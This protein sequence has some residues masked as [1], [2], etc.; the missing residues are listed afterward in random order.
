V[1]NERGKIYWTQKG[2]SNA[3]IGSIRRANIDIPDGEDPA[4]RSIS[5][6]FSM[7]CLSH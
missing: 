4:H 5:K 6:C 7:A 3:G 2:G 1:D